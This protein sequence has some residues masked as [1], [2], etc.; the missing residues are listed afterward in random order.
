MA[1]SRETNLRHQLFGLWCAPIFT[2][3]TLVGFLWLA[4]FWAPAPADMTA[5]QMAEFFT[6]THRDGIL[7]GC[8]IFLFSCV[9]L[10]IYTG[11]LSIL[12]AE[13]EGR[14]PVWAIA[15]AM[16]GLSVAIIV[17]LDCSFWI[18]AAYRP[19]ASPDVIVAMNDA[20]W[21]GFLLA[22][23]VLSLQMVA[24]A[25]VSLAD[26]SPRPMFPRWLSWASLAGAALL[27]TA[28]GPAFTHS[29][30]FAYHG[31]LG[32]YVPM[33]IWGVWLDVHAW[34]ARSALLARMAVPRRSERA[35]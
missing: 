12:L 11:Q 4:H 13:V 3:L 35:A 1:V 27:L 7:L 10:A 20:A 8:S 28:G 34:Y 21:L 31:L 15:Q 5:E 9:F 2:V 17:I 26:E 16:G 32:F 23:P 18:S 6:V 25:V 33:V 19:G 14:A 24:A 30:P 29:G 22:W